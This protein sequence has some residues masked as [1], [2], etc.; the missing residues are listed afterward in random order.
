MEE[1][2]QRTGNFLPRADR[3]TNQLLQVDA[4]IV[5]L[6]APASVA[7]EQYRVLYHR[8]ERLR[9]A[10]P[11]KVITLTSAVSG[12]GKSMTAANLAL[13]AAAA[14]PGRR[15]L[16]IDADL[17]R[18]TQSLL[19]GVEGRPGLGEFLSG[20]AALQEVMHRPGGSSLLVLPAGAPREEPGPLIASEPMRLLLEQ[21]REHFEEVYIDAPPVL[22]VADGGL[23]AAMADGAILVAR[24]GSTPR[25]LVG[26]A[27]ESLA[28]SRVLGCVLNGIDAGEV[29]YLTRN[30]VR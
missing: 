4:T 12:E 28:G 8:L 1:V 9:T 30:R 23:L 22:P 20:D 7:A 6:T 5:A 29:P 21:A 26:Q 11:M 18:P 13:V 19:L 27:L 2:L 17:R 16:L 3:L 25:A 15:V 14:S 24:A 10:R